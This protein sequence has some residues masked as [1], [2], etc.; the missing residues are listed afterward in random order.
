MSNP[1]KMK[2]GNSTSFKMMGS[3]PMKTHT[4]ESGNPIPHEGAGRAATGA[5]EFFTNVAIIDRKS[6]EY[7]QDIRNQITQGGGNPDDKQW[8]EKYVPPKFWK[9]TK[10]DIETG[11]HVVGGTGAE[12][13]KDMLLPSGQKPG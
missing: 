8:Q 10:E 9:I 13:T 1:F 7:N 12:I 11:T 2:S 4:D 6:H 5:V 3:S